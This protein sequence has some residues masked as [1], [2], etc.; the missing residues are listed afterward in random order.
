[1]SAHRH[2]LTRGVWPLEKLQSYGVGLLPLAMAAGL[3]SGGLL[4]QPPAPEPA[5]TI[6]KPAERPPDADSFTTPWLSD[7]RPVMDV[8]ADAMGLATQRDAPA[9]V[10]TSGASALD[11]PSP[12]RVAH[13]IATMRRG[14]GVESEPPCQPVAAPLTRAERTLDAYLLAEKD[15]GGSSRQLRVSVAE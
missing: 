10:F 3:L 5:R 4:R 1:M 13:A 7:L 2:A 15:A 9:R 11:T 6:G 12:L 14:I 8:L